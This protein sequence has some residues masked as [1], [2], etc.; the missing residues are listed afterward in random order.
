MFAL[1]VWFHAGIIVMAGLPLSMLQ[2]RWNFHMLKKKMYGFHS[3]I[4]FISIL[5]YLQVR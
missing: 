5:T 1:P 2:D 4:V 3:F